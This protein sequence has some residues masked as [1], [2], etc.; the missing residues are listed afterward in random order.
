VN[1]RRELRVSPI[2][3]ILV[4]GAISLLAWL[5]LWRMPELPLLVLLA[6]QPIKPFLLAKVPLFGAIDPTLIVAIWLIG[7]ICWQGAFRRSSLDRSG[8]PVFLAQAALAGWVLVS[9]LWTSAP[10][11]GLYKGLRFAALN[12]AVLLA[13]SVLV[14]DSASLRRL[15]LGV[16]LIACVVYAK[17]SVYPSYEISALTE[18]DA[19]FRAGFIYGG[20]AASY[21]HQLA[22]AICI[23][24]LASA[25]GWGLR[26]LSIAGAVS[27]M[28]G[29]WLTGTRASVMALVL[30]AVL[31]A[32]L[33]VRQANVQR[34]VGVALIVIGAI[35]AAY[36]ASPVEQQR[37]IV[38]GFTSVD[39]SGLSRFEH[40]DTAIRAFEDAPLVGGGIGSYAVFSRG[41][42]M[43]WFPH[44]IVLETL[45]ELGAFG[46][47][48]MLLVFASFVAC[49]LPLRRR[50]VARVKNPEAL[51]IGDAWV[52]GAIASLAVSLITDDLADNR[53]IWMAMGV[54]L[55][56]YNYPAAAALHRD[57]AMAKP[58]LAT[59]EIENVCQS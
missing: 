42:D 56:A 50:A 6:L 21:S 15:T 20:D 46:G 16:A 33:R 12:S 3:I 7:Q 49:T 11:Y 2:L 38:N 48:L 27:L 59:G 37:R 23:G 1:A 57:R 8:Q 18:R 19:Y 14:R 40:W 36:V 58:K 54:A 10:N 41:T 32:L 51:Y 22:G 24:A 39:D 55:V 17:I 53:S 28:L 52:I 43:R 44:S 35:S 13:P 47:A 25:R 9:L 26:L 29:A 30:S 31:W 34:F 5:S 4:V 45:A